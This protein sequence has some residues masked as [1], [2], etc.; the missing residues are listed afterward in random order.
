MYGSVETMPVT[1]EEHCYDSLYVIRCI[2]TLCEDSGE[3]QAAGQVS[4]K[5]CIAGHSKFPDKIR[6]RVLTDYPVYGNAPPRN[7][8]LPP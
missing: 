7:D 3:E 6:A 2:R 4:K 5:Y 8:P 1:G